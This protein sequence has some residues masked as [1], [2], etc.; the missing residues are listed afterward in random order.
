MLVRNNVLLF[1]PYNWHELL[2]HSRCTTND[3]LLIKFYCTLKLKALCEGKVQSATVQ[4]FTPSPTFFST[5]AYSLLIKSRNF[6]F[7]ERKNGL[8]KVAACDSAELSET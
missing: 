7:I 5:D 4:Q 1:Y 8:R 2:N 3:D 6:C